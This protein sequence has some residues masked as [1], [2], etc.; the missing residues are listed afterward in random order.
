LNELER[1]THSDSAGRFRL[2]NLPGG[3]YTLSVQRL[4]YA[5]T[6]RRVALAAG[7]TTA[8]ELTL[9]R[10]QLGTDAIT[11][12]GTP[13][14]QD[15]LRS[16]TEVSALSGVEKFRAQ[17][18]SIGATL[19]D[20]P[21]VQ[22]ISTGGVSGKPVIRGL[23]GNRIKMMHNSIG[24]Q[25]Q[26]FGVRHMPPMD[27]FLAERIEVVEGPASI[28]YGSDAMGGAV[29]FMPVQAPVHPEHPDELTAELMSD[30][31]HNARQGTGAL[32]LSGKAGRLG[33][34]GGLLYRRAGNMRTPDVRSFEDP[35]GQPDDPRFTGELDNT[36]YEQL[37]GTATLTYD[38]GI[39]DISLNY[40]RWG[41][42]HNFLLP[43][44]KGL[45]Q[46]I[47][48]DI[49][50]LSGRFA[51]G[52]HFLLKPT[53]TYLRNRR[54]SNPKGQ[55]R[56]ELP[57]H[58]SNSGHLN[59][60]REDYAARLELKHF[61]TGRFS[62]TVG[63]QGR[64]GDQTTHG[65]TEPLVPS[66]A[67]YNIGVFALEEFQLERLSLTAGAR[68]DYRTQEASP[69]ARLALPDSGE[70]EGVL[71]QDYAEF[72]GSLGANYQ[73]TEQFTISASAGRAFRAPSMFDLHVHGVHGGVAA[74]QE[75]NPTLA[76]E[77][78]LNTEL[79]LQWRSP[80][81]KASAT[82][83]RN[84]I[85]NYIYLQNTGQSSAAGP[86]LLVNRQTDAAIWGTHYSVQVQ[87][88]EW[89]QVGT[90]GQFVRGQSRRADDGI[91]E[92]PLMPANRL[93]GHLRFQLP[94]LG[95]VTN[96]FFEPRL[97]H[98]FAKDAAGRYE[99]FWQ[100]GPAFP[101]GVASTEAYTL[102]GA[103][104]GAD[105]KLGRRP[106]HLLFY[107]ENLTNEA[108]RTFLDTYKGYALSPGIN[109]GVRVSVPVTLLR[110]GR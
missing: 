36:D 91:D 61:G 94:S 89:L 62:G 43:N 31:Q 29:N 37:N 93:G 78:S 54:I 103:R 79:R 80:R 110:R 68:F 35:Q 6:Q 83:Y 34:A 86:P 12:T 16:T 24:M 69:D 11:V 106:V 63:L 71:S 73:V 21:G 26:Q 38:A 85:N 87:A 65:A 51:L 9:P 4:G 56:D 100:F 48:N 33:L 55:T 96:A 45:G 30:Y 99:P 50:Q 18:P 57:A 27:A 70:S 7:D 8:V 66:A 60:L 92:L 104:L 109:V 39:G 53:I 72:T 67:L 101:F 52:S 41:N 59:I 10:S 88:L 77:R 23:T 1:E 2:R 98:V 97:Q 25:Y 108:Y 3:D 22:N 107:G 19:A 47:G 14:A 42:E 76:P 82:G 84:A 40:T 17:Q 49:A 15:P 75:G 44:G 81:L 95:P 105:L 64:Y 20:Q 58:C 28:L 46:H 74:F 13:G 32:K 102:L 5:Q 90:S